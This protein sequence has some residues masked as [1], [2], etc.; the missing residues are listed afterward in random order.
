MNPADVLTRP[1]SPTKLKDCNLWFFGLLFLHSNEQGGST[2]YTSSIVEDDIECKVSTLTASPSTYFIF[3]IQHGNSFGRKLRNTGDSAIN[4]DA[5]TKA[6][7]IQLTY[8]RKKR[9]N[10]LY[11]ALSE[12]SNNKTSRTKSA[13]YKSLE[14]CF[15]PPTH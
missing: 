2:A 15:I 6:S 14:N 5:N 12:P 3:Q 7:P 4:A 13:S 11:S 10:R 8:W 9:E 1:M